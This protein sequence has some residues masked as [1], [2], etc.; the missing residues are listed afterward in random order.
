MRLLKVLRILWILAN[1]LYENIDQDN[2]SDDRM[3]LY[4]LAKSLTELVYQRR[5]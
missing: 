5:P 2:V 3:F 4:D 1:F